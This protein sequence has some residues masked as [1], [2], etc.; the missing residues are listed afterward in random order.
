MDSR[1]VNISLFIV[2]AYTIYRANQ[3]YQTLEDKKIIEPH[4]DVPHILTLWTMLGVFFN[5]AY[6]FCRGFLNLTP[7]QVDILFCGYTAPGAGFI[8]LV[9]WSM[10]L[11]MPGLIMTDEVKREIS[12]VFNHLLFGAGENSRPC[13]FS[14]N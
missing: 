14:N 5:T 11:T 7:R 10:E 9:F 12:P 4:P 8:G 3:F 2:H 6:R 13:V 1:P